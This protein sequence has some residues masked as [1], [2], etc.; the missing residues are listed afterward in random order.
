MEDQ[1]DKSESKGLVDAY[2]DEFADDLQRRLENETKDL[3]VEAYFD[4]M[5][6]E[7]DEL[8]RANSDRKL[9]TSSSV[10]TLPPVLSKPI[11]KF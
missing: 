2:S 1:S 4:E 10:P 5:N 6:D 8:T 9:P 11:E 3:K 7:D